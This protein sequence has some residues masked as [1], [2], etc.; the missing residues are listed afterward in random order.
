MSAMEGEFG[1]DLI[2]RDDG[3][4][5]CIDV[6]SRAANSEGGVLAFAGEAGIGKTRLLEAL[7]GLARKRGFAV[8]SARGSE[9]EREFPFGIV[10]QLFER[11][12]VAMSPGDRSAVFTGQ[13]EL[14]G[15]A[16]DLPR[17]DGPT[18]EASLATIHGLYW[19]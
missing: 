12:V 10:R 17:V 14:A 19:L 7:V 13:A 3:L 8:A 5:V 2:E 18:R 4:G 6:L 1:I 11:Q 15:R 16:F 9:L